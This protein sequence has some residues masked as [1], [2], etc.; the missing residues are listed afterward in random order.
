MALVAG[1]TAIWNGASETLDVPSLTLIVI[2]P[3][4]PT[5]AAAGLPESAPDVVLKI[6]QAGLLA[7]EKVNLAPAAAVTVG[8]KAYGV[9][10]ATTAGGVPAIAGALWAAPAPEAF[11]AETVAASTG[12]IDGVV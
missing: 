1:V 2:P 10:A 9:P 7:I 3:K 5:S 6:A 12:A 8:S 11:D 4:V